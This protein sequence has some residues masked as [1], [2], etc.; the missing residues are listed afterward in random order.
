MWIDQRYRLKCDGAVFPVTNGN[1]LK[2]AIETRTYTFLDNATRF[3]GVELN[4]V[5]ETDGATVLDYMSDR[6]LENQGSALEPT[7]R[8]YYDRLRRYGA[9]HCRALPDTSA[10]ADREL[11]RADPLT[12][13]PARPE[14]KAM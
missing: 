3:W 9:R 1:P 8:N 2:Y 4:F 5:D 12:S 6:I 11:L 13:A 10:C 14:R 7:L